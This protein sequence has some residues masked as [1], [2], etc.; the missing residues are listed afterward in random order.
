MLGRS[1]EKS[2]VS[3]KGNTGDNTEVWK[4]PEKRNYF[5]CVDVLAEFYLV[6]LGH[7]RIYRNPKMKY[8][9]YL[10]SK[11]CDEYIDLLAFEITKSQYL[12]PTWYGMSIDSHLES[13]VVISGQ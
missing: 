2:V 11:I 3:T 9:P 10:S 13:V 7:I 12:K 8:M 1:Y 6:P 4:C 5:A